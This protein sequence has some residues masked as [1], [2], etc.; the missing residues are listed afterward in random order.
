MRSLELQC[1][2]TFQLLYKYS[3]KFIVV[4]NIARMIIIIKKKKKKKVHIILLY[5]NK[6]NI[7]FLNENVYNILHY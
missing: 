2:I 5:N 1:I 7:K 3:L 6:F 4:N